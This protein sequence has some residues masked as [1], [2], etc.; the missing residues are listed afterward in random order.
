[1]KPGKMHNPLKALL[2]A[3]SISWLCVW[4]H[5]QKWVAVFSRPK[6]LSQYPNP[7]V[8]L[9]KSQPLLVP[10]HH[11]DRL[12]DPHQWNGQGLPWAFRL[13]LSM[14][15]V[16]VK[17]RS[18]LKYCFNCPILLLVHTR[19]SNP[20]LTSPSSDSLAT[21]LWEWPKVV[22]H[23]ICEFLPHPDFCT[24]TDVWVTL[25]FWLLS[26]VSLSSKTSRA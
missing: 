12:C 2:R 14:K 18:S 4:L 1:M 3:L 17:I 13:C 9:G 7:S 26:T 11:F 16:S 15:Y 19:S 22:L 8:F 25:T 6:T 21:S 5:L 24:T 23:G 20:S 10:W